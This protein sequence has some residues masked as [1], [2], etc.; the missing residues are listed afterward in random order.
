MFSYIS[1]TRF[2]VKPEGGQQCIFEKTNGGS[3]ETLGLKEP[4]GEL[5]CPNPRQIETCTNLIINSLYSV[6]ILQ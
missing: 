4:E 3:M 1:S 6:H 5:N 2:V